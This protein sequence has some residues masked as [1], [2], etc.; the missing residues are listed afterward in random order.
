MIY[1]EWKLKKKSSEN[2]HA[3]GVPLPDPRS[4]PGVQYVHLRHASSIDSDIILLRKKKIISCK[5]M[6]QQIQQISH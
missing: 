5:T 1:G 3:V 4:Q 6:L 2:T